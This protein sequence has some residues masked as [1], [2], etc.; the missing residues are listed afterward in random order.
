M[1]MKN[2]Y[3]YRKQFPL[4][5]AYAITI[6]KCQGLSLDC[7]IIDLSENVFSDGMAYVA[8]SRVRSLSGLHLVAFHPKSIMVSINSLQETNRLRK[9]NTKL[10]LYSLPTQSKT[11]RKRKITS[12]NDQPDGPD[13][14]KLT[15]CSKLLK[16][17]TKQKKRAL[18]A[19]NL[20]CDK[21]AKKSLLH[22]GNDYNPRDEQVWPFK[23]Y[24]VDE[25]WQHNACTTLGLQYVTSNRLRP[26]G[27]NVD[28]RPPN[29]IKR[30][31]GDGNCL[32]RSFS[33]IITGSEEQHMAVR[34]AILNH[35]IDIAHF[36]LGH[37]IPPQYSSVQDYIQDKGMDQPHIWG[38]EIEMFT[39]AHLLQTCVFIY[40]TDDLNWCRYSPRGVD[41]TLND[42]IQ[43]M[44]MYINHPPNHFEVVRSIQQH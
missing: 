32:F 13:P 3:V 8:L 41:R 25:H 43:Q 40:N 39:L 34:I 24:S 27:P 5:L 18:T 28:L 31:G 15:P 16:T 20:D 6:H 1:V 12:K 36:L 37:H 10:P 9:Q 4:I 2:Y 14:K 35:M 21:P 11:N 33:Y 7:A 17:N 26:G 38:T 42:D 30:I 44:S 22:Y 19:T 29:H 23:F